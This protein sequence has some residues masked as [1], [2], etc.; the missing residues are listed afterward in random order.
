MDLNTAFNN[1]HRKKGKEEM[2]ETM[3]G[4]KDGRR[5]K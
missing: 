2:E 3:K 5:K 1:F 4:K